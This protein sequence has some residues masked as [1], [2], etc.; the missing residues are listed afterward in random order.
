MVMCLQRFNPLS[1]LTAANFSLIVV[2]LSYQSGIIKYNE[3]RSTITDIMVEYAKY[4]TL[5]L[6]ETPSNPT[7]PKPKKAKRYSYSVD[8]YWGC[9]SKKLNID[10]R[11]ICKSKKKETILEELILKPFFHLSLET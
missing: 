9:C 1:D 11:T 3:T 2:R 4:L 10:N 5:N 7:I 6:S 8:K